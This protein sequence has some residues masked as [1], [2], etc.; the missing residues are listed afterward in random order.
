MS[1]TGFA[2]HTFGVFLRPIGEGEA[3]RLVYSPI[4]GALVVIPL[5]GGQKKKRG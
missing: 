5:Y 4:A 2:V 3:D 1:L